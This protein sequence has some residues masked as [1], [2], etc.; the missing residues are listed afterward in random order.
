M[1][2]H[3]Q[4]FQEQS[5]SWILAADNYHALSKAVFK[6][7]L[8]DGFR[9]RLQFNPGRI[10]SSSANI[11]KDAIKARPC[12]LCKKNRPA[13]QD[14]LMFEE[15][16]LNAKFQI[17]V[18]PFPVFPQHFTIASTE[19]QPQAIEGQ[20]YALLKLA[21][22]MDDCV[23]FYNGPRC[24]ASAP[25]HLHFQAGSKGLMPIESDYDGWKESHLSSLYK[26]NGV[27]LFKMEHFLRYGWMMEGNDLTAL[28]HHFELLLETLTSVE[29]DG[30]VDPM[31]NLLCWYSEGKWICAVFPRKAHR[32]ECYFKEDESKLLISP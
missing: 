27:Q 24:G 7:F 13:E 29:S 8:I 26:E 18:N 15:K 4:L 9:I 17:L 19:H 32:P 25:D 14:F 30:G 23:V 22:K 21:E 20:F 12:F 6:E 16:D 10:V 2:D 31:L 11:S 28:I 5:T 3:K 1:H